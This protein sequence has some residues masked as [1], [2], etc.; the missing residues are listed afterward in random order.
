MLTRDTNGHSQVEIIMANL[1]DKT[2]RKIPNKRE[3]LKSC[4]EMS[5]IFFSQLKMMNWAIGK[6]LTGFCLF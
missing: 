1:L 2:T 5:V 4:R 6:R 3:P